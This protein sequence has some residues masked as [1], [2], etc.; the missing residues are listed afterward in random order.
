MVDAVDD[1]LKSDG[2]EKWRLKAIRANVLRDGRRV[3]VDATSDEAS[4]DWA[5][6]IV[7]HTQALLRKPTG[8][9]IRLDEGRTMRQYLL[10]E[11]S[12]PPITDLQAIEGQLPLEATGRDMVPYAPKHWD[13]FIGRNFY[14]LVSRPMNWMSR[15]PMF[16]HS[17][18]NAYDGALESLRAATGAPDEMLEEQAH[19][20]AVERAVRETVPFIHN[21]KVRSQMAIVG[22]NFA[23]F[24]FAQEQF[25]KRWARV[26][27][28]A[29]ESFRQAQLV[30][31][32]L[33]NV[34]FLHTDE[35]GQ[36]YFNY[37][38]IGFGQ[39][40]VQRTLGRLVG[41]GNVYLAVEPGLSGQIQFIAPGL[42]Q[43]APSV[44]PLVSMPLTAL[45]YAFPE[46]TRIRNDVV[47]PLA[48]PEPANERS[49]LGAVA[50]Q[51]V[52]TVVSRMWQAMF[53]SPGNS[54]VMANNM[55]AAAQY[56]ET[57]GHGLPA[58]YTPTQF[59]IW[60]GRVQNWARNLMILQAIVGTVVPAS[61]Q[62]EVDPLGLKADYAALLNTMPYEQAVAEYI[63][64]HP[65][66]VPYTV[67]GTTT[68]GG[69]FLPATKNALSFL[70]AN[71]GFMA[72]HPY[73]GI[74]LMPLTTTEGPFS[75][76]AYLA[77]LATG[78]RSRKEFSDWYQDVKVAEI[79]G[80]YY[81]VDTAIQNLITAE[82]GETQQLT[83]FWN[84][85]SDQVKAANPIFA[86][87]V[88][89]E[90][91]HAERVQ[92][93]ADMQSA[94]ASPDLPL[95]PTVSAVAQ[96]QQGYNEVQEFAS[97]TTGYSSYS[98]QRTAMKDAYLAWA[99]AFVQSNPLAAP[100]WNGILSLE[101][102][103]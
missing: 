22:R 9:A 38:A 2:Y 96:L 54:A 14:H 39:Q 67:S 86:E 50:E 17:Y 79:G 37:P 71:S 72:A 11:R 7:D 102:P 4:R 40:F 24:Y 18:A 46:I 59:G 41:D 23:P 25:W 101:V 12:G 97:E 35:N 66:G 60:Q 1:L 8:G 64:L 29:P 16:V 63:K 31:N 56:L 53:A 48:G 100:Y 51:G 10:D 95:S 5:N 58:D 94:L 65:D 45:A 84:T 6:T 83:H 85:W 88:D 92:V 74:W 3:G 103:S 87:H 55:I 26:L 28:Y 21:P 47:G 42:D 44:G 49:M 20:I 33:R 15:E 90:A 89:G 70:D 27:R 82:P 13:K 61:P 43:V 32:G 99:A 80:T 34:G 69:A 68:E 73:A 93:I 30:M 77:E 36:E 76:A 57:T 98:T 91:A 78:L 62:I 81:T 52:P 19:E 75:D